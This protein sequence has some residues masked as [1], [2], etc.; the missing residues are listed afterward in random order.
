MK[1]K[2]DKKILSF[3]LKQIEVLK[4]ILLDGWSVV[5]LVGHN[6]IFVALLEKSNFNNE[7]FLYIPPRKKINI[8]S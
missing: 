1:Y 7:E 3:E 2:Q 5:N 4:Q 6:K 8:T